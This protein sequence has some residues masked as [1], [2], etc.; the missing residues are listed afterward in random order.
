MTPTQALAVTNH[1]ALLAPIAGP[2]AVP[3]ETLL[4]VQSAEAR[5][6]HGAVGVGEALLE[7]Q[8]LA[9]RATALTGRTWLVRPKGL[10]EFEELLLADVVLAVL[11]APEA[12]AP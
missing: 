11:V 12:V 7:D 1:D 4:G 8:R 2:F 6:A 9:L 10:E 5:T 3:A